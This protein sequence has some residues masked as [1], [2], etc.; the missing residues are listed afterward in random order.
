MQ[1]SVAYSSVPKT[2]IALSA[3]II[4][5]GCIPPSFYVQASNDP[6]GCELEF[7][8]GQ[9]S[10]LAICLNERVV[11]PGNRTIVEQARELRNQAREVSP[12]GR[13]IPER[14]AQFAIGGCETPLWARLTITLQQLY[15]VHDAS[16]AP[17]IEHN[18]L[19][20]DLLDGH[21]D[22][23]ELLRRHIE[24]LDEADASGPRTWQR[25][26]EVDVAM[27]ATLPH[28]DNF[29]TTHDRISSI[30]WCETVKA[31]AEYVRSSDFLSNLPDDPTRLYG[32]WYTSQHAD[33][34]L[35]LQRLALEALQPFA[36]SGDRPSMYFAYLYDRVAIGE[37]RSQRYGTQSCF[38]ADGSFDLCPLEDG[39]ELAERRIRSG[40]SPT[41]R[42][43]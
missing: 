9:L 29:R 24:F 8:T 6:S 35:D 34:D 23:L 22:K 40:L 39:L 36:E 27:N 25:L 31:N 13:R 38:Q 17:R 37:G 26:V 15:S 16:N 30:L 12:I 18:S 19:L 14:A 32:I 41:P 28:A 3:A 2:T 21:A 4:V 42:R 1:R 5:A 43:R 7:G 20:L 10:D 11:E 33:H